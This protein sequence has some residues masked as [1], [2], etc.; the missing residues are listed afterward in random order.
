M[1]SEFFGSELDV[2]VPEAVPCAL[3][4]AQCLEIALAR[5]GPE[6]SH[7]VNTEAKEKQSVLDSR[8]FQI[9]KTAYFSHHELGVLWEGQEGSFCRICM[10]AMS[11][12]S[13]TLKEELIVRNSPQ[14]I[15][16]NIPIKN[17]WFGKR[18]WPLL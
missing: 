18:F 5:A 1:F 6:S 14:M 4:S 11:A 2:L 15:L 9:T 8:P 13:E 17:H 16:M 10:P 3:A 12:V 7:F